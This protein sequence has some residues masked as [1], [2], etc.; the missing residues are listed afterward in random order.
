MTEETITALRNYD[1]MVRNRG[2]DE[3][4]LAWDSDSLV[5]GEGGAAIE[6]LTEP[7]FTPAT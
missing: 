6:L 3:V 1:W 4:Q 7:G 2:L 5:Y